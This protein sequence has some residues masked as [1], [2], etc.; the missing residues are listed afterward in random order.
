MIATP[1]YPVCRRLVDE[2]FFATLYGPYVISEPSTDPDIGG[3][4]IYLGST[5]ATAAVP[6]LAD[7]A[8]LE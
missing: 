1:L 2:R 6:W 7:V 4:G 8:R 3:F 5:K